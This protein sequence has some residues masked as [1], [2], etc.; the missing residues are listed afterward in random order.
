MMLRSAWTHTLRMELAHLDSVVTA[1]NDVAAGQSAESA[2]AISIIDADV[3]S[4][5]LPSGKSFCSPLQKHMHLSL[6]A[7]DAQWHGAHRQ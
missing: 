7:D 6:A 1:D 5:M 4:R 3:L 2:K